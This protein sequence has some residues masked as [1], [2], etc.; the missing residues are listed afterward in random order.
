MRDFISSA[1][2]EGEQPSVGDLRF[3][4][5]DSHERGIYLIEL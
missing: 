4:P 3:M 2:G 5:V 1:I